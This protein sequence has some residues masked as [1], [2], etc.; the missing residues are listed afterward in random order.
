[1]AQTVDLDL[2]FVNLAISNW[3]LIGNPGAAEYSAYVDSD[4]SF[5]TADISRTD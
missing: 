5:S 4:P 1:M 2:L 3:L